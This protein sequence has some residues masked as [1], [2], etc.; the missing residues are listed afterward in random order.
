MLL[1]KLAAGCVAKY[2]LRFLFFKDVRLG[3]ISIKYGR[4]LSYTRILQFFH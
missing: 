3:I 2:G 1:K 4:G